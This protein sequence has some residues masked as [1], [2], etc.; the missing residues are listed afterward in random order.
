MPTHQNSTTVLERLSLIIVKYETETLLTASPNP[1]MASA[2]VT[3][4][5]TVQPTDRDVTYKPTGTVTITVNGST[6]CTVELDPET[7]KGSCDI[8]V[9]DIGGDY[10]DFGQ[11]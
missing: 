4:S 1:L 11:L 3:F 2:P 9:F 5:V 7:G 6:G 10:T 8:D